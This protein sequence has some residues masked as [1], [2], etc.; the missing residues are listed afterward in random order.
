MAPRSMSCGRGA[1]ARARLI[2]PATSCTSALSARSDWA[3]I[4]AVPDT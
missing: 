1:A 4:V 3:E 2:D